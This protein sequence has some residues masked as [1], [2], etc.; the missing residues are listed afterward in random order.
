MQEHKSFLDKLTEPFDQAQLVEHRRCL[1][2]KMLQVNEFASRW[3]SGVVN[4]TEVLC[5][6]CRKN[7]ADKARIVC[8][9][10][11]RLQGFMDP[12]RAKT[13][14]VFKS[15]HHYHIAKCP[16]CAPESNATPVL[17]HEAFCRDQKIVTKTNLD[18]LQEI[19]QKSL[20]VRSEADKLRAELNFQRK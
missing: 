14:F 5:G 11:K 16:K 12:Q 1:C 17:E 20:R 13:G 2:G 19:E 18:L 10:C 6:D 3:Y 9:G 15:R 4:Y 8:V 7:F